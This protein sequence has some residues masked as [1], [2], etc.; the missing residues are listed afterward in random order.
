MQ[1]CISAGVRAEESKQ[2]YCTCCSQRCLEV[3]VFSLTADLRVHVTASERVPKLWK[4]QHVQQQCVHLSVGVRP[5]VQPVHIQLSS[6]SSRAAVSTEPLAASSLV[7]VC[8]QLV[9]R[10]D[11]AVQSSEAC[12]YS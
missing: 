7:Q 8:S 4:R 9:S 2:R 10:H 5:E 3:N 11:P 1:P 12:Y 6:T